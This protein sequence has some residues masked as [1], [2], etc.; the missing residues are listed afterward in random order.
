MTL[1]WDKDNNF[2][3]FTSD[4]NYD[5]TVWSSN[6]WVSIWPVGSNTFKIY[7]TP[8]GKSN[9]YFAKETKNPPLWYSLF[10]KRVNYKKVRIV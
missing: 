1:I 6:E 2:V 8:I 4:F 5:Q 9:F 3:C 10:L 7:G